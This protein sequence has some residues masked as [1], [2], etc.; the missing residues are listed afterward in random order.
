MGNRDWRKLTF[1]LLCPALFLFTGS[2]QAAS[3]GK[4]EVASRLGEPFY[5][6]VPLKLESNEL[7]SKVF[8][9]IAAPSDY[10]IFEVY[11]DPILKAIRADVASDK[12]G[13][14]VEL[15][16]R[17]RIKS[18]FFNLVLKIRYGRVSHFKKFPVFLDAPKS[19]Q[20]AA[21]KA[22]QP[23]L[24]AI[25][26]PVATAPR[27]SLTKSAGQVFIPEPAIAATTSLEPESTYYEGWARTDR[28][29]PIVRGDTLSTVAER[30]RIDYRY[31]RNQ[32]MMALFEKNRSSFDQNNI[33]LLKAGSRLNVPTAA[34]VEQHHKS[35]ASRF[36]TE[37][38]KK[39]KELT[40]QP[41]YAAEKEAQ[42]TR[43]TKR[44]SVGEHADGVATAPVAVAEAAHK[45]ALA[46]P[47][48]PLT[49][50]KKQPQ[51]NKQKSAAP[52]DSTAAQT[53]EIAAAVAQAQ[54]ESS[55]MVDELRQ[56]NVL[57]QQ[58]LGNNQKSI[59]TLNRKIEGD[60]VTAAAAKAHLDKLE[61]LISRL[62]SELEAVERQKSASVS[63]G[64]DWMI[65]ILIALVLLL[66]GV[67]AILMRREPTH[68]AV[69]MESSA[70][71][72]AAETI[73]EGRSERPGLDSAHEAADTETAEP[74]K[75]TATIDSLPV[76]TDEL[77]DTDTAELEPFDADADVEPDPDIDYLAEADVYIRYGMDDEAIKQ[78]DMALRLQPDYVE[79]HIK[80]A[81]LLLG[82][83]DKS[84]LD[85]SVAAATATL[86]AVD[87]E[88]FKASIEKMETKTDHHFPESETQQPQPDLDETVQDA[89]PLDESAAD[90][91]DFDLSEL[92]VP[93]IEHDKQQDE[94]DQLDM[95]DFDLTGGAT[96][97]LD[98]LLSEFD[99]DE[100]DAIRFVDTQH[101]LEASVFEQDDDKEIDKNDDSRDDSRDDS[102]RGDKKN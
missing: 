9:E 72:A 89:L 100:D 55:R 102:S 88:R 38:E 71:D 67:V 53:S 70:P 80:K 64:M 61:I 94:Q 66:I 51:V 92:D 24:D 36:L 20:Q 43:Y 39:W 90:D 82:K 31:S 97:E 95:P 32:I 62:Q 8:V 76:F 87:L 40:R 26:Q 42:R 37:Q 34:E 10:K 69:A 45:T 41:R 52:V 77:S 17:S 73:S 29:G 25:K 68:P 96:Q 19:I 84:G 63:A 65:W 83:S 13:V 101:G 91:L 93:D 5:A 59:E 16:S 79:A 27:T 18:P 33:N 30:L 54:A 47:I 14:R 15:S 44:I 4:I 78:V 60:V 57:L 12:R 35:E 58:Q 21:S 85:D 99:E 86:A 50:F 46:A 74:D 22:P 81:E 49:Q 11:R 98:Q 48:K 1:V 2:V 28:Y 23:S 75:E 3:P 7:A 56:Q 6:E